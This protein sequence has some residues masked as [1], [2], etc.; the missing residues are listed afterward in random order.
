M[1]YAIGDSS[2]GESYLIANGGMYHDNDSEVG[3][4]EITA[5]DDDDDDLSTSSG[6]RHG[7]LLQPEPE[8]Y[9]VT[10]VS[11]MAT[12]EGC[13]PETNG[14]LLRLPRSLYCDISLPT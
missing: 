13:R 8:D 11:G 4:E 3:A 6:R 14:P 1:P 5:D 12:F 9:A 7:N 2:Y 10:E